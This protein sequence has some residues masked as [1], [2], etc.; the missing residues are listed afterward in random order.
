MKTLLYKEYIREVL[1]DN[2][3]LFSVGNDY[4]FICI[5]NKNVTHSLEQPIFTHVTKTDYIKWV[6]D[7]ILDN[8]ID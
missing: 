6:R 2:Y 7:N 1:G 5:Y 8:L 3:E 4:E